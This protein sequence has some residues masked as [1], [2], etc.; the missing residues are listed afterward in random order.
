MPSVHRYSSTNLGVLKP[1]NA[2]DSVEVEAVEAASAA[3]ASAA[4]A[5]AEADSEASKEN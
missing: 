2:V 1:T 5:S 3:V 4:V